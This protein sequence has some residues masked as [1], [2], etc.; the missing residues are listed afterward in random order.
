MAKK[1]VVAS[2]V[3]FCVAA[4]AII[5]C[6]S[7]RAGEDHPASVDAVPILR[8]ASEIARRQDEPQ[9]Y[10]CD[11]A[12]LDVADAQV[13][14]GDFDG[15]RHTIRSSGYEHG[16]H[17]ALAA[18]ARAMARSG[19]REQ[20]LVVLRETETDHGWSQD[21]LEDGVKMSYAEHQMSIDEL[22]GAR[23]TVDEMATPESRA[24]GLRNLAVANASLGDMV[25][26][27]DLF[28][29]ASTVSKTISDEYSRA[30]ALWEIADAQLAHARHAAAGTIRE[31]AAASELYRDPWTRA[32]ALRE[33]AVLAV[34]MDD[35]Q[36]AKRLFGQAVDCRQAIGQESRA[37]ALS[38][39]ARA[40]ATA[41]YINDAR[42]TTY[43][44]A[45]LQRD[46]TMCTIAIAQA[47]TKD[48]A[49]A[50]ATALSVDREQGLSGA[51]AGIADVQIRNGDMAGAVATAKQ[52]PNASEK[53]TALLRV[54]TAYARSGD[55]ETA[56]AVAR[57]IRMEREPGVAVRVQVDFDYQRPDTW[58]RLYDM[59]SFTFTMGRLQSS[60]QRAQELAAAAMTLA[61]TLGEQHSVPYAQAFRD[62]PAEVVQAIAPT[63][64][65]IGDVKGVLAW[66]RQIG[67]EDGSVSRDNT[68]AAES[69]RRRIHGLLGVAE[70]ILDRRRSR[71]AQE[72]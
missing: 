8:E 27:A 38:A 29:R 13:R 58:W 1:V 9:S 40:Q 39:I 31:L 52:I 48:I 65:A 50:I 10:W 68:D 22:E 36:A 30:K 56:E 34:K 11:R 41:G 72:D 49:G 12:L 3:S 2:P 71:Q 5:C 62:A 42:A 33:V 19:Q 20:A 70:G 4:A 57:A 17:R 51:W 45:G 69:V 23:R 16:R 18:L 43:M 6:Q 7:A 60:L 54:A 35:Q 26:A 64:A 37:N 28:R 25:A 63:H 46:V 44:I 21:H 59:M 24:G 47:R 66:V 61:Q 15:A 32:A 14:A 67:S 55:R 53:A